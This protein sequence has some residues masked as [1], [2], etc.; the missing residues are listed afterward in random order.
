MPKT[1]A[2]LP[3]SQYATALELVLGKLLEAA[4]LFAE[5]LDKMDASEPSVALLRRA[6]V[7]F[8]LVAFRTEGEGRG[9]AGRREE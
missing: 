9:V 5:A 3:S 1:L 2:A 4:L 7:V 6:W 8:H